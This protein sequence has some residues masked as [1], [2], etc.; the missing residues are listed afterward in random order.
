MHDRPLFE[1]ELVDA[2]IGDDTR[3]KGIVWT[4]TEHPRVVNVREAGVGAA[5]HGRY[6]GLLYRWRRGLD[7]GAADRPDDGGD[8]LA[9]AEF[10]K[11]QHRPGIGGLIVFNHKL[12]LLTKNA[13]LLVDFLDCELGAIEG[14][15]AGLR[16]RAGNFADQADTNGVR[17]NRGQPDERCC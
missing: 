1:L 13:A 4:A 3:G 2:E 9:P 8:L 11:R 5:D 15:A 7:L 16:V 6:A 17:R 12:D 14:V 10:R